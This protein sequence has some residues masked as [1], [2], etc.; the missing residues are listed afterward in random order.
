M[1]PDLM[2]ARLAQIE[3]ELKELTAQVGAGADVDKK[4]SE[5]PDPFDRLTISNK[6]DELTKEREALVQLLTDTPGSTLP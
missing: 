6:I 5:V 3:T 2:A 4:L 1:T